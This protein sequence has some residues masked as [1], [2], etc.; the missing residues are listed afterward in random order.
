LWG[1]EGRARGMGIFQKNL[2]NL[3]QRKP[4]KELKRARE[5]IE[6]KSSKCFLLSLF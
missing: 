5:A 6:K 1:G 2:K 3:A 4:L